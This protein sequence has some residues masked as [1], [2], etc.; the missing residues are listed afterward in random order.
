MI[1]IKE[2]QPQY[3]AVEKVTLQDGFYLPFTENICKITV[4]DVL[5][6]FEKD[7]AIENYLRIAR[8]ERGQHGGYPWFHGLICETLRGLSDLL[9]HHCAKAIAD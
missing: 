4:P 2:L 7:G 6:K 9:L 8:G 3:P 5:A 1:R